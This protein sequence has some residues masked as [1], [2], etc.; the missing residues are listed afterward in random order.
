M[1]I[2]INQGEASGQEV[3]HLHVHLMPRWHNDGGGAVQSLVA[4][5]SPNSL[6]DIAS[7]ILGK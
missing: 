2:G 7:K 1:T 4:N 6:D 3:G 5:P